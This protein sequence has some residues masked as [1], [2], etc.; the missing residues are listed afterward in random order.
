MKNQDIDKSI[1]E[2]REKLNELSAII[3]LRMDMQKYPVSIKGKVQELQ[4]RLEYRTKQY[5]SQLLDEK[6]DIYE[7]VIKHLKV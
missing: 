2:K 3:A 7:Q 4:D 1:D 5:E 6:I